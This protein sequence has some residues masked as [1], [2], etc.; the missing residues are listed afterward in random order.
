M[1]GKSKTMYIVSLCTIVVSIILI[2]IGNFYWQN[3]NNAIIASSK[4]DAPELIKDTLE[5]KDFYQK[6]KDKENLNALIIGDSI[7]QSSGTGD[8]EYFWFTQLNE[9]LMKE[10]KLNH[11]TT[12]KL[13]AGGA[14]V[15]DGFVKF[16]PSETV[17]LYDIVFIAFGQN[18]VNVMK[19][20][21]F[22]VFYENLIREIKEKH[23]KAEIVTL[24]E[25]SLKGEE[26]PNV[27]KNLSKR[28][29]TILVDTRIPFYNSGKTMEE[30]TVDTVHPTNEGYTM[31]ANEIFNTLKKNIED[32]KKIAQYNKQ[33]VYPEY[34]YDEIEKDSAF[35]TT[36]GFDG[37]VFEQKSYLKSETKG[38]YLEAEFEGS[39]IGFTLLG[40]DDSGIINVYIDN[41]L[42]LEVNPYT[43]EPREKHIYVANNLTDGKHKIKIEVSGKPGYD[44]KGKPVKG[45]SAIISD[46][47][48]YKKTK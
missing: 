18:D 13:T 20:D 34:K 24:I 41:K 30:L 39:L 27:I 21:E 6:I 48:T 40:T 25:S 45:T 5:Y 7:G 8:E 12:Q 15:F 47:I 17:F 28:H 42:V 3:K 9:K 38:S 31:Y 32:N 36:E 44:Y 14:T 11:I 35:P 2:L 29:N 22:G 1:Y 23:P 10:Y 26:Y 4:K 46:L 33:P 37:Y 43:P 16:N 19:P